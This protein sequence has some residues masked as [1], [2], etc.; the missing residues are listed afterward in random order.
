MASR[1]TVA[2]ITFE[3]VFFR[4]PFEAPLELPYSARPKTDLEVRQTRR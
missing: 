1:I 2:P 3:D 4:P